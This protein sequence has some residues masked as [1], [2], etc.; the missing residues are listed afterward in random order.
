METIQKFLAKRKFKKTT[1]LCP[2]DRQ[3]CFIMGEHVD[4]PDRRSG[5]TS[6]IA[7]Y[8]YSLMEKGKEVCI[9]VDNHSQVVH[10]MNLFKGFNPRVQIRKNNTASLPVKGSGR[11]KFFV[12]GF[13]P[14]NCHADVFLSDTT[15][16]KTA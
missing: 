7:F 9:T 3:L 8:A 15:E 1:G 12:Q 14:K 13:K 4:W 11:V 10:Y 6:T 2:S 5:K 16:D